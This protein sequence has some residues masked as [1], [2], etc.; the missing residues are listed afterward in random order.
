[1]SSAPEPTSR[2]SDNTTDVLNYQSIGSIGSDNDEYYR[3]IDENQFPH[4]IENDKIYNFEITVKKY[5][6]LIIVQM[7]KVNLLP[8]I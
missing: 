7:I 3:E 8:M 6:F 4:K 2:K 1:M 5:I